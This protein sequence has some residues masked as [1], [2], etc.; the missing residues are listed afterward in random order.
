MP[1][2]YGLR[3]Y[4][5]FI[6]EV[7]SQEIWND[8]YGLVPFLFRGYYFLSC[9]CF[10]D[11][12]DFTCMAVFFALMREILHACR[13]SGR[14]SVPLNA[15]ELPYCYRSTDS[16]WHSLIRLLLCALYIATVVQNPRPGQKR[17]P[18]ALLRYFVLFS[19]SSAF[20]ECRSFPST[21]S[22]SCRWLC[23]QTPCSCFLNLSLTY[24]SLGISGILSIR[25]K[26]RG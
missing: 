23:N 11:A 4:T 7:M 22:F 3:I 26:N 19:K 17:I 21:F 14:K 13:E 10:I 15:G 8:V 6:D 24:F 18:F 20:M 25:G 1:L 12:G 9:C 16:H 2:I 5:T